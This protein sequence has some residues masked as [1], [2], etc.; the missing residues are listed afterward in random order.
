MSRTHLP[1]SDRPVKW[2]MIKDL[3]VH[4]IEAQRPL[5]HNKVIDIA[6]ALDPDGIGVIC[7]AEI[8][9]GNSEVTY[10]I[11]DGQHRVAAVR[12][13][14]GE[15]ER[16]PCEII[17]DVDTP[18]E[19]A[20]IW[21]LRN[22]AQTAPT[23]YERFNVAVTANRELEV[24]VNEIIKACGYT[25]GW[26]ELMAVVACITAYKQV[27]AE[28]LAWVLTTLRDTW[29]I[30]DKD[31]VRG[32]LVRGYA[33]FWR[34]H[35]SKIDSDRLIKVVSERYTPNRLLGAAKTSRDT[36]R[37]TMAENVNRVLVTTYNYRL[38][39]PSR[40]RHE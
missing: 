34:D 20:E 4:W 39:E 10:H 21:L 24:T 5:R 6:N 9:N 3:D 8:K 18:E 33:L 26:G 30:E 22:T 35:G 1:K 17:Q 25:V 13:L 32:S 11:I 38:T 15:S 29:G 23:S 7:V 14:W 19:A 31:A 37:G 28:G 16:V 36:F 2:M 27:G 40:L 12:Q